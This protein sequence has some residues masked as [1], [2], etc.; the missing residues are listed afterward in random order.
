MK[1]GC[2]LCTSPARMYCESDGASLCWD[3]DA[4][5]HSANFLVAKHSRCLLCH[6][7]QSLTPWLA[8]GTDLGR[9]ISVCVTC[10]ADNRHKRQHEPAAAHSQPEIAGRNTVQRDRSDHE[11]IEEEEEEEEEVSDSEGENSSSDGDCDD[12]EGEN[13]VVPWSCSPSLPHPGTDFSGSED[14]SSS[15]TLSPRG[16]SSSIRKFKYCDDIDVA[17]SG[18][19]D[20]DCCSSILHREDAAT[21]EVTSSPAASASEGQEETSSLIRSYYRPRKVI[22]Q[23]SVVTPTTEGERD[24]MVRTRKRFKQSTGANNG[25]GDGGS[26]WNMQK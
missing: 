18:E 11:D 14:L 19:Y 1:K 16:V 12:E 2:E 22:R 15:C 17:G 8:S 21:P 7:C 25:G 4:K 3:C 10:A 9:A 6:L 26:V 13:Q 24:E 23:E 5:V 20:T